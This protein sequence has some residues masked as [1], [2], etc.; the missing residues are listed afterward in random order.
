M[1]NHNSDKQW[2]IM[3]LFNNNSLVIDLE[4]SDVSSEFIFRIHNNFQ[5]VPNSISSNKNKHSVCSPINL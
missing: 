1:A 3:K 2:W 5:N 4:N